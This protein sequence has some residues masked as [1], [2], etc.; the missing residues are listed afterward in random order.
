MSQHTAAI[1]LGGKPR[2]PQEAN[3][4][5]VR[6]MNCGNLQGALDIFT[7]I[8]T[9]ASHPVMSMNLG[10]AKQGMKHH[11]RALASF[12]RVIALAPDFAGAYNNR[13]I[14]LHALKRYDEA[15]ASYDKAIALKPDDSAAY[16]NRAMTLHALDRYQDTLESCEKAV[17][18]YSRPRRAP[19][20]PW[21]RT[22]GDGTIC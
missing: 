21:Q 15:L 7:L 17:A 1:H 12:D 14:S 10:L 16:T 6:E 18:L 4:I 9:K 22:S 2:T 13:G 20:Q 8:L 3:D 19:Q 5:A 11:E